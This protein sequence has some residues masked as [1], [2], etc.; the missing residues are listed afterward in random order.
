MVPLS[1]KYCS[2]ILVFVSFGLVIFWIANP[3]FTYL[4]IINLN[5]FTTMV[6]YTGLWE[7]KIYGEMKARWG[8]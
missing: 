1:V 8:L 4:N 5:F 6:G 3:F 7:N 2:F